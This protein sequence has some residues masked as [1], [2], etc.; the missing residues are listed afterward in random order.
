M[1]P[2]SKILKV[3]SQKKAV[4][5]NREERRAVKVNDKIS[6]IEINKLWRKFIKSHPY[7]STWKKKGARQ[8]IIACDDLV[9][10]VEL[11]VSTGRAMM[12]IDVQMGLNGDM[13]VI[14]RDQYGPFQSTTFYATRRLSR[15]VG[16][17]VN[18]VNTDWHCGTKEHMQE[19]LSEMKSLLNQHVVPFIDR[20][21]S[22]DTRQSA[23]E[24]L[25]PNAMCRLPLTLYETGIVGVRRDLKQNLISSSPFRFKEKTCTWF[26]ANGILSVT[27]AEYLRIAVLQMEENFRERARSLAAEL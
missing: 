23:F 15:K 26:L 12:A 16:L 6:M 4:D 8:Y 20:A 18:D 1:N 22:L 21:L 17:A 10:G 11:L 2:F 19:D 13:K 25:M 7:F 5:Q 3:I 14:E 9:C 27:Q 24:L